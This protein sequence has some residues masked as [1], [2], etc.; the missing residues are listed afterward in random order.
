[1]QCAAPCVGIRCSI[2]RDVEECEVGKCRPQRLRDAASTQ[3]GGE[4]V[5]H[6]EPPQRGYDRAGIGDLFE[7]LANLVSDLVR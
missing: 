5:G 7:N 2:D 1:M 3:R 4:A 6:V